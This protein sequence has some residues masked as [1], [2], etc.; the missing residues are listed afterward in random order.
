MEYKELEKLWK[1]YDERLNNLEEINRKLLKETLLRK[2]QNMLNW[3][4][5][6]NIYGLIVCPIV[7]SIVFYPIF[8]AE[9]TGWQFILGCI[10]MMIVLLYLYVGRIKIYLITKKMDLSS[11]SVTQ[12]LNNAIKLKRIASGWVRKF[13]FIYYPI[14]FFSV[15]F[16]CWNGI[17]FDAKTI[18]FLSVLFVGIFCW[19]IL[20]M[21]LYK[22]NL[23][24]LE[25][26]IM[27]L[28]EYTER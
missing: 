11:D 27:E 16:I 15:I 22:E 20:K 5:Y 7:L 17:T 12:S 6:S 4:K 28:R 24:K 3:L 9:N 18:V 10:L 25:K 23:G 21:G 1:Q 14:M 8:K 26:D 19:G 2:P 13:V